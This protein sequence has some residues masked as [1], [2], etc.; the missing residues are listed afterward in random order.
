MYL[1]NT[2]VAKRRSVS[3]LEN[4]YLCRQQ[5][6]PGA[7]LSEKLHLLREVELRWGQPHF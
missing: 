1:Y 6:S 4:A 2:A 5:N 7:V 3:S